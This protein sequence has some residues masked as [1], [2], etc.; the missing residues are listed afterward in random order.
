MM[1]AHELLLFALTILPLAAF[2]QVPGSGVVCRKELTTSNNCYRLYLPA[3]APKGLVVLLP[4]Y[5]ED[6]N[7]FQRFRISQF[8]S[9]KQ[10]ACMAVSHAGYL[11]DSDL[12]TLLALV[13]EVAAAQK[14]PPGKI[15][16]AG[17][18]AG[19]TGAFKYVQY[20]AVHDC[21][22]LKPAAVVFVDAP[23]DLERWWKSQ[24]INLRRN[25]PASHLDESKTILEV[26]AMAMAGSPNEVRDTYRAKSPVLASEKD[27]GNARLVTIPTRLYTEPD[28]N[29]MLDNWKSDYYTSNAIDQ[30]ALILQL[31]AQ[32]NQRAEL[33]TTSGKGFNPDGK[34]NPH[35]WTIVDE[36]DLARWITNVLR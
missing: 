27:G 8:L 31:R 4:K 34:R 23:L 35:S 1:R 26:L 10:I 7:A 20:C 25:N 14:I 32:G 17:I 15:V 6:A 3:S 19:G 21:G 12:P 29:W 13:R 33:V 22:P 9:K 2:S 36:E 11:F 24:E 18:S 28:I 16:V 30:A 5:G